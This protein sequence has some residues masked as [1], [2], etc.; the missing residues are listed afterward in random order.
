[1]AISAK[2]R[3]AS[4]L[5]ISAG[6]AKRMTKVPSAWMSATVAAPSRVARYTPSA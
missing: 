3:C 4:E 5:K 2:G 1:L 6:S